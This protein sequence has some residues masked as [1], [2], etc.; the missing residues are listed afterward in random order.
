MGSLFECGLCH[1]RNMN[2]R[3]LIPGNAPDEFTLMGIRRACLDAMWNRETSTVSGNFWRLQQD[4]HDS[5]EVFS[6]KK[7]MPVIGTDDVKDR[8]GMGITL[9]TLNSSLRMGR[10]LDTIQWDTMRKTPTWWTNAFEAGEEYGE[11]AIYSSNDK[12][13][14]ESTA[15]A[16]SR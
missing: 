15:P 14:Y 12:K 4:Y 3:D 7:P 8:V 1:F 9:M 5:M 13:V 16:A 2:E 10:Y 6:I 11:G